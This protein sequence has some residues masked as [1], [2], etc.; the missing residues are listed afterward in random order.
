KKGIKRH[1]TVAGT[2]QQNGLAERMNRTLLERVRCM[3]LGA[4]L[5][6]SFWGEAVTTAAYLINICPSTGIDL[7][8]PMEVWS[9]RPADYS[10]LKVFRS[11]A[12]AHIRQDKLDA[13]AEKCVFLG[14]PEGVKGYRLWKMEPGGSKFIISRDVTFD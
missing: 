11:L 10:N 2:P 9:G 4:G 14:Y 8:T 13:R 12:F 5:P 6:K 7:K 1:R 3:L